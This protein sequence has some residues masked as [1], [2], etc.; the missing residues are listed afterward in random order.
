[1][2][3]AKERLR[4]KKLRKSGK[5]IKDIAKILGISTSSASLWCRDIILTQKQ[6]DRLK[7]KATDP[8]YGKRGSYIKKRIEETNKK[9]ARL[10]KEGVKSIGKLTKRE[11]FLIGVALYWGEGF[12]KDHQLGLATSDT[13]IAKFYIYWLEKCFNISANDLIVRVTSNISYKDSIK[14]LEKY[15]AAQLNLAYGQF[16]KPYFQKTVWKKQY[17]NKD[18]YHGV[19]RIKVR[20]SINFLRKMY[21]YIEGINLSIFSSPTRLKNGLFLE[22][23]L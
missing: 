6:I 19:I 22:K 23:D 1:M 9:I 2:A 11:I 5:S 4:A 14:S 3:K 10:K 20:R 8:Y 16:S 7:Q 12:K 13:G 15:W 21:G 18:Q 17:E